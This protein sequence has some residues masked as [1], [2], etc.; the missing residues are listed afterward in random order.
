M[1]GTYW[2]RGGE[3]PLRARPRDQS[4]AV[5]LVIT[6][7]PPPNCQT[8]KRS[9]LSS[10]CRIRRVW[11]SARAWHHQ[12]SRRR[13]ASCAQKHAYHTRDRRD[14]TR[15]PSQ[16]KHRNYRNNTKRLMNLASVVPTA[17]DE[18]HTASLI[19]TNDAFSLSSNERRDEV[20][21]HVARKLELCAQRHTAHKPP[22]RPT[23]LIRAISSGTWGKP[24]RVGD[25]T[26]GPGRGPGRRERIPGEP[27]ALTAHRVTALSP[28]PIPP[29]HHGPEGHS[30]GAKGMVTS[31]C[32]R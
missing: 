3:G 14:R 17:L 24:P 4:N 25:S 13:H 23:T 30:H 5:R 19:P 8:G 16:P 2:M 21:V 29:R 1:V 7:A 26:N 6:G 18:S 15:R 28:G 20:V 12:L 31:T 22:L 32:G 27:S 11:T 10:V 9:N